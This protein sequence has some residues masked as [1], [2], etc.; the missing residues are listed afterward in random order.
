VTTVELSSGYDR[1]AR[2]LA[3]AAGAEERLE[4]RQ[5]DFAASADEVEPA[6]VV[7][8]N[9]V[10]CCYPDYEGLLGSAAGR[11]QRLL[12]FSFP[13][14]TWWTRLGATLGNWFLR[15]RRCEFRGYVH[16]PGALYETAERQG[17]RLA[18]EH[19]GLLWRVAGFERAA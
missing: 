14:S 13:R 8:L 3:E 1:L 15:L 11:S 10:V 18:Y 4:R 2:E 6:D 19:Q 16:P 7:V 5:L 17:F 9:R 12:A